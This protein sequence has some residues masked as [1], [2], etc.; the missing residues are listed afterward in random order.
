MSYL[1]LFWSFIQ[2]GLFSIGGGYAAIS[3][4]Q[5]QVIEKHHWLT[6]TQFSDLITIAEMTPG[7][8]AIN[9]A[10]FVGT[11]IG[12]IPGALVATAGCLLPAFII[13]SSLAFAYYKYRN[14]SIIRG[15]LDGLSPAVVA[16]IASAGT[17]ILILALWGEKGFNL[18]ITRL[19]FIAVLLFIGA[20]LLLRKFKKSPIFTMVI[21]GAMG[22]IIYSIK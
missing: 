21:C 19:N 20:F 1:E 12:G 13:V 4:I 5:E 15:I 11:Q 22:M 17:S 3:L 6:L 9:A 2:V 14:L 10:T 18:S 7:A 8:I 16:M